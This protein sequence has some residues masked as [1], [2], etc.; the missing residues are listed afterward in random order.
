MVA[1]AAREADGAG[2]G[3]YFA[4][5][6]RVRWGE[7]DP[8]GIAY[9]PRFF[10]WMDLALHALAREMGISIADTL[11]P[12]GLGFPLV[13]AEAAFIAPV[14]QDDV[15]EVRAWVTHVGAS[16]L[17][18]RHQIVRVSDGALVAHGRETRVHVSRA[19]D[20]SLRPRRLTEPMR[21]VL[22]RYARA[23]DRAADEPTAAAG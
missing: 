13:Q 21:E 11:P 5:R 17:A 7:C 6:T 12:L 2:A 22:A 20:G 9:Y 16:S 23:P 1:R 4:V 10:E 18:L 8:A 3:P 19:D 15:L 14:R